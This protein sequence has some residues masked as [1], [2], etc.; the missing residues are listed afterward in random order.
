MIAALIAAGAAILTPHFHDWWR[1]GLSDRRS[2]ASFYGELANI[3]R[4]YY[5]SY[6][7]VPDEISHPDFKLRLALAEYGTAAVSRR[8]V[9]RIPLEP[10]EINRSMEMLILIRNNDIRVQELQGQ[11][12]ADLAAQ[13]LR[14]LKARMK[15]CRDLAEGLL[16]SIY[17]RKKTLFDPPPILD[18]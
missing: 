16:A 8:R 2:L 6:R 5:H 7:E 1:Q 10:D 15:D 18:H 17:E 14:T 12:T 11:G 13:Q 3:Y 4:H 9:A